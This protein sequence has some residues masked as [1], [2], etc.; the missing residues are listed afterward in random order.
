M[1]A[2]R[3]VKRWRSAPGAVTGTPPPAVAG[4]VVF[5]GSFDHRLRAFDAA[6]GA[7]RWTAPTGGVLRSSPAVANGMV[8]EGSYDHS[9]HAFDAGTGMPLWAFQTGDRVRSSPAGA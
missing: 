2:A 6:T 3:G 7:P 8:F 9:V 5:V 1:T 4:G